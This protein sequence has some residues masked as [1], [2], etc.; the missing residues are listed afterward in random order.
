MAW[1]RGTV[2]S[3]QQLKRLG[4]HKYSSSGSTLLDPY[5]Q[6]FWNWFVLK[7]PLDIAPNT[8]TS[9]GL[10]VNFVT[11]LTLI[12]SSSDAKQEVPRWAPLLFA[13]GLFFYQTLDAC[14]GKQARRTSSSSPLG[15]LFDH[16]CDSLSTVFVALATCISVQL[17]QHPDWMFYQCMAAS[18]LFYTAHWQTYVSGTLKFGKFDVTEAQFTVIAIHL[19]SAIF[20]TGMWSTEVSLGF[21]D[22]QLKIV[23]MYV[24]LAGSCYPIS[25]YFSTILNGGVGKNGSTIADTSI[26]SP[27]APLAVVIIPAVVIYKKSSTNLLEHHP[28]LYLMTFG[29]VLAKVTN[30]LVV[31][32]M[33]KS[34]IGVLDLVL[35]GPAMLFLNQYFNEP[36]S[37]YYVLWAAFF[38]TLADLLWY[39]F[40]VCTEISEHLAIN[41]FS[42]KP[43]LQSSASSS[44]SEKPNNR[45]DTVHNSNGRS[46]RHYNLRKT[47]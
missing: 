39:A 20:G 18:A 41:V 35:I 8:L 33:T 34:E 13:V 12:I 29:L 16:G 38:W 17:G 44:R 36:I 14:D 2:M 32:H 30:K 27:L 42:I 6:R 46:Q 28:C 31:A 22:C 23:A 11:T 43:R 19:I 15:E 45:R 40:K 26:L 9:I 37:D 21:V 25:Q 24:M 3:E 10:A 4:E 7:I 5:M 1:S 47:Q